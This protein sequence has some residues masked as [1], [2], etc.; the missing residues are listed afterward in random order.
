MS[1]RRKELGDFLSALRQ[2]CEPAA[3]GF[4]PGLRRRTRGLRR[5]EV[6]QLAQISPTWYAWIEQGREISVSSDVL[7]R[8][9]AALRMDKTQRAYLF[10]LAGRHDNQPAAP[11][12]SMPPALLAQIVEDFAAPAYILDRYWDVI[13][14]NAPAAVLFGPWMNAAHAPNLLRFVFLDPAA[15]TLVEDWETRARRLAAEFRADSRSSLDDPALLQQ[16]EALSQASPEFAHFWKL[17]DVLERQGGLRGFA[18]PQQGH[19]AFQQVTFRL[20]DHEQLKLVLLMA[21]SA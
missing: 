11:E 13:A 16:V 5:E 18:H 21:E 3:F 6:A 15:R 1:I 10:E 17:H 19:L 2:K 14:W 7:D 4:P 20:V 12:H 9:A 8:L